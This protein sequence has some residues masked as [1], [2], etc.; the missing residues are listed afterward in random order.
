MAQRAGTSGERSQS[1]RGERLR[2]PLPRSRSSPPRSGLV[3]RQR[4]RMCT[5]RLRDRFLRTM[6]Y[7][8]WNRCPNPVEM[9]RGLNKYPPVEWYRIRGPFHPPVDPTDRLD[10]HRTGG[11]GTRNRAAASLSGTGDMP[12]RIRPVSRLRSTP[13]LTARPVA[14]RDPTDRTHPTP[15][16]GRAEPTGP[17]PHPGG[18]GARTPETSSEPNRPVVWPGPDRTGERPSRPDRQGDLAISLS[19]TKA[20]VK[21]KSVPTFTPPSGSAPGRVRGGCGLPCGGGA[22]AGSA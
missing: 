18:S 19:A 10:P 1:R 8:V 6:A 11:P 13:R 3:L 16:G 21:L 22:I 4:R 5:R 14:G 2:R 20:R 15:A 7:L 12:G 17:E 9:G